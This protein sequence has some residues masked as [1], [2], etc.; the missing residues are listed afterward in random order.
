MYFSSKVSAQTLWFSGCMEEA[1]RHSL[2]SPVAISDNKSL[3][4]LQDLSGFPSEA[5]GNTGEEQQIKETD[6]DDLHVFPQ[7]LKETNSD[8]WL[9]DLRGHGD[10]EDG[11]AVS[12]SLQCPT[13]W[14]PSRGCH[15]K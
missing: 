2:G 12:P 6:A 13:Y 9:V 8:S 14:F 3:P 1:F 11:L 15:R 10:D 4:S 7:S 5:L